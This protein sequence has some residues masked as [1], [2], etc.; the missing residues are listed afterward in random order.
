VPF[1]PLAG[2]G[3]E[4]LANST[5]NTSKVNLFSWFDWIPLNS[6]CQCNRRQ[7]YFFNCLS[8][9]YKNVIYN[10]RRIP[11]SA[12]KAKSSSSWLSFPSSPCPMF[13]FSR[14][15]TNS[16]LFGKE[17][18]AEYHS[19]GQC[20]LGPGYFWR[21]FKSRPACMCSMTSVGV[22][23][24]SEPENAL[25]AKQAHENHSPDSWNPPSLLSITTES[26]WFPGNHYNPSQNFL[27]RRSCVQNVNSFCT[28]RVLGGSE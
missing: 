20:K 19:R 5:R 1:G 9:K 7:F 25:T 3:S 17:L 11:S 27:L 4:L 6:K 13:E 26:P 24:L 2:P 18:L 22:V 21:C 15:C 23:R 10:F 12:T 8:H 14:Y 16:E 28:N